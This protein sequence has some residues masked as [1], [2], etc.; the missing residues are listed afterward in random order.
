MYSSCISLVSVF[1]LPPC[2]FASGQSLSSLYLFF[3][4][5]LLCFLGYVGQYVL[6]L[7]LYGKISVQIRRWLFL[8]SVEASRSGRRVRFIGRVFAVESSF[9]SL[10]ASTGDFSFTPVSLSAVKSCGSV[11]EVDFPDIAVLGFIMDGSVLSTLIFSGFLRR[12]CDF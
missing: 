12:V 10:R 4:C 8:K 7:N 9:R 3:F 5:L 1:P 11:L 2:A 6:V